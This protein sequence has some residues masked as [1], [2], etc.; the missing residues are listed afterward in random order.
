VD[1]VPDP[2][3]LRKSLSA[4]NRTRN[5]WICSHELWPLDHRGGLYIYIYIRIFLFRLKWKTTE[6]Q[7]GNHAN[8]FLFGDDTDKHATFGALW[9]RDA[10][11]CEIFSRVTKATSMAKVHISAI[12]CWKEPIFVGRNVVCSSFV[13]EKFELVMWQVSGS[14]NIRKYGALVGRYWNIQK[15]I[16]FSSE[17]SEKS[18]HFTAAIPSV[19]NSDCRL[20]YSKRC[21]GAMCVCVCVCVCLCVCVCGTQGAVSTAKRC[22]GRQAL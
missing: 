4:V 3:L 14:A 15:E 7:P 22:G 9:K 17:Y 1:P 5:L 21:E 19:G 6:W 11:L 12:S 20:H 18:G 2:L 8:C 13:I 10:I 16:W